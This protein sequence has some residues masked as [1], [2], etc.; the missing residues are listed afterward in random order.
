[1]Y[2]IPCKLCFEVLFII[3]VGW[4]KLKQYYFESR[5]CQGF[6]TSVSD[7]GQLDSFSFLH[8]Q[9]GPPIVLALPAVT[10]PS[11]SLPLLKLYAS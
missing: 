1:M 3:K 11:L 9:S 7:S 4:K 5:H 2:N 10:N 8:C 6:V